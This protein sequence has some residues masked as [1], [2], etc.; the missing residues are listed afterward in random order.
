MGEIMIEK[1]ALI[2]IAIVALFVLGLF[3]KMRYYR[4]TVDIQDEI[5][6]DLLNEAGENN[7][8]MLAMGLRSEE[9][10]EKQ[11][12]KLVDYT[13]ALIK[14]GMWGEYLL[15]KRGEQNVRNNYKAS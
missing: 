10:F 1:I 12:Q 5:C 9:D 11:Q 2:L 15:K 7:R 6:L 13:D 14:G 3:A 8:M 4:K